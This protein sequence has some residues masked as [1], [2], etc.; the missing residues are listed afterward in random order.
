V[1]RRPFTPISGSMFTSFAIV[2]TYLAV[3]VPA[4]AL[5]IAGL[6]LIAG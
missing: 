1:I 4:L 2:L 5:L 3:F 6:A